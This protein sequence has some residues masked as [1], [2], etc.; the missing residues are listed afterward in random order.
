MSTFIPDPA[1]LFIPTH[2][3]GR[4]CAHAGC[5]TILSIYNPAELCALHEAEGEAFKA[6]RVCGR[7]L[8]RDLDHFYANYTTADGL[9][10]QCK[11]CASKAQAAAQKR[12][13][14]AQVAAWKR[15][16]ERQ[17]ERYREKKRQEATP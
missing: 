8:P 16:N 10:S 7:T 9:K 1:E 11:A 3:R 6:C 13:R 14:E 15:G 2:P 17:R 12:R 4:R 5:S